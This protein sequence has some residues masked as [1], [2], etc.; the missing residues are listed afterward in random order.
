VKCEACGSETPET[1][2][3]C[4]NC[5]KPFRTAKKTTNPGTNKPTKTLLVVLGVFS[6]LGFGYILG[7]Y[8][9]YLPFG[10]SRFYLS[11]QFREKA[12]PAYVALNRMDYEKLNIMGAAYQNARGEAEAALVEASPLVRTDADREAY[13][14]LRHLLESMW[15]EDAAEE[16]LREETLSQPLPNMTFNQDRIYNCGIVARVYFDPASGQ[17]DE[18]ILRQC[19]SGCFTEWKD[20]LRS[21]QSRLPQQQTE[22]QPEQDDA[23]AILSPLSVPQGIKAAAWDAYYQSKS[24]ADFD[25]RFS[26]IDLSP[27]V[28]TRLRKKRFSR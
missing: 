24:A 22:A 3:L 8:D 20:Y 17:G 28:K 19:R 21:Q 16:M 14:A 10:N 13:I 27:E 26:K 2:V 12:T 7:G 6:V 9:L 23:Q 11:P 15:D 5:G 4:P 18:K 1:W 25:Q